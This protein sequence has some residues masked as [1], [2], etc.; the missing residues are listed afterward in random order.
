MRRQTILWLSAPVFAV[1]AYANTSDGAHTT[2]SRHEKLEKFFQSFGCPTPH[3]VKEYVLAADTYA[4]DYRLLPVISVLE[5]TCGIYERQ[6]NRWGWDS[7]RK[8]FA[9]FRTGLEFI[10]RQL[11]VGRYYKNKTLEQK[12]RTYNP[13]PEYSRQVDRLMRKIEDH[14]AALDQDANSPPSIRVVFP[15]ADPFLKGRQN[16]WRLRRWRVVLFLRESSDSGATV[17]GLR[18]LNRNFSFPPQSL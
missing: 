16:D 1:A 8:G 11:A 3:H 7:A 15:V 12:V 9:S 13:N 17:N 10:A 2:D 18:M 4:I 6:N 14:S 5:S